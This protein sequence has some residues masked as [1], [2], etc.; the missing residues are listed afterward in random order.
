MV[1]TVIRDKQLWDGLNSKGCVPNKS[2]ILNF[3]EESIFSNKSLIYDFIRGYVDGD[4]TLGVYPHSKTNPKLEESLSIVGTKAFLEG[5]QKYLGTGFL[6]QK[7][8]CNENTYRL[9]YSTSKANKA[10]ELLYKNANI[11]LNRK[12]NIYINKF[13][14]V[15]SGK[16]GES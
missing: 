7:P 3:P 8:N 12:Y 5:V 6:M 14:A 10:A 11:Y 4:G 9:G 13:A 15:K 16:N 1:S 2:L